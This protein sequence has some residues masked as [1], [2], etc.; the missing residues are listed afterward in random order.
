M[1]V[2][3]RDGGAVLA[4]DFQH[5]GQTQP[6]AIRAG[7]QRPIKRLEHQFAFCGGYAGA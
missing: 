7:A 5:D 6:G 4:R 3:E 1:R 2:I